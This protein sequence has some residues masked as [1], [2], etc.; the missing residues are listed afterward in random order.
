MWTQIHANIVDSHIGMIEYFP[1]ISR[2]LI[3]LVYALDGTEVKFT[4]TV[5]EAKSMVEHLQNVILVQESRFYK[6]EQ[7]EHP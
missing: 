7:N 2:P 4:I 1:M 5:D 3:H 6:G